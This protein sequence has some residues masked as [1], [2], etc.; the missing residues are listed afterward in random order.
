ML[1]KQGNPWEPGCGCPISAASITV[2]QPLDTHSGAGQI[3][4]LTLAAQYLAGEMAPGLVDP[5]GWDLNSIG[6]GQFDRLRDR[7]EPDSG[8]HADRHADVVSA[9]R[10]APTTATAS[11]TRATRSTSLQT[12]SDLD[13][14]ILRNGTLIAESTSNVDNVE[15]LHFDR[16]P[17]RPSTRCAC[18]GL[19]VYG[20]S[21]QFALAWYG[22]AVPEPASLALAVLAAIGLALLRRRSFRDGAVKFS[23]NRLTAR[24]PSCSMSVPGRDLGHE[25]VLVYLWATNRTSGFDDRER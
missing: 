4:G 25:P 16:R 7:S 18:R 20:G 13:L 12:L 1:D 22:T 14:Q 10:A 9:R 6:N 23:P 21:E 17:G 2:T 11:S 3:D 5:I 15:H 19:N 8:Q 24:G